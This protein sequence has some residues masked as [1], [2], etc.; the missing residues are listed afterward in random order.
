MDTAYETLYTIDLVVKI[1]LQI[2]G[3]CALC[4]WIITTKGR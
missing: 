1:I 3:I 2:I 4:I